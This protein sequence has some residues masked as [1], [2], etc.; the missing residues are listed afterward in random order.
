MRA[1][2]PKGN[3]VLG[4]LQPFSKD[5]L[6]FL[7]NMIASYGDVVR[8]RFAHVQ[9]H[10]INDPDLIEDVLLRRSNAFD[11]NTRSVAKIQSTCGDSLL[12]ANETAWTRHKKLI[13][14]AFLRQYIENCDP[15][16]DA[17]THEM[18]I[19]WHK[20][21][22]AGTP[23]DIVSEMMHLVITISAKVLFGTQVNSEL[24]ETA[25]DVVLADTWRRL[26]SPIDFSNLSPALHRPKFKRAKAQIDEI[27]FD[28]ITERRNSNKTHDDVLSWLLTAHKS[29]N[30]PSLSNQELRD[31]ALT[32][33]LAGHETTATALAWSVISIARAPQSGLEAANMEHIFAETVRLYPSIWIIERRV[34]QDMQL[35]DYDIKKG[36]SVLICPYLLH[37]HKSHWP[38]AETFNP[39]RFE[40]QNM[41]NRIRNTYLP[42]GQG[43]HS[44]IGKHLSKRIATR[45][46]ENVYAK[47]RL[48]LNPRQSLELDAGI[49]LRHKNP[50]MMTLKPL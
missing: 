50:V 42:F 33:L 15:Q 22:Q 3:L 32:L 10:L 4:S 21:A 24:L 43:K 39:A 37:R 30:N 34:K 25:L 2:G 45:V 49:T 28:I 13:Q 20:F 35:G 29:E 46:L 40:S 6:G 36:S 26:Q 31:A 44:C 17:I 14:P 47:F 41:D 11:K 8:L 38:D 48:E 23:I 16:I 27:V 9:T 1:P 12:S 7:G 19:R 5:S 18:T